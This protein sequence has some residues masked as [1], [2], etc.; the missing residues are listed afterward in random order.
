MP[1]MLQDQRLMLRTT[2]SQRCNMTKQSKRPTSWRVRTRTATGCEQTVLL[3]EREH[4]AEGRGALRVSA[5]A[6]DSTARWLLRF[7]SFA[8]TVYLGRRGGRFWARLVSRP[9]HPPL[10]PVAAPP[11][12]AACGVRTPWPLFDRVHRRETHPHHD[13]S[14]A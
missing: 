4:S 10:D 8:C 2:H 6:H 12:A 7:D 3:S 13:N 1:L 5:A 11:R 9:P 14:E